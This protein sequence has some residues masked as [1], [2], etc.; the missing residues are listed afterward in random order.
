MIYDKKVINRKDMR[1]YF[2]FLFPVPA[3]TPCFAGPGQL[4]VHKKFFI[5][6]I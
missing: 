5:T 3:G 1:P 2:G 6:T 4:F